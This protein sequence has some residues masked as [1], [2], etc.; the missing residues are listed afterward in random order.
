MCET[1]VGKRYKN[2][3]VKE[4]FSLGKRRINLNVSVTVLTFGFHGQ[5]MVATIGCHSGSTKESIS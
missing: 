3:T 2:S 5:R 1:F 4:K